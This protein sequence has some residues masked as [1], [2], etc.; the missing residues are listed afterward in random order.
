MRSPCGRA[1]VCVHVDHQAQ[2][3]LGAALGE[4]DARL[5]QDFVLAFARDHPDETAVLRVIGKLAAGDPYLPGVVHIPPLRLTKFWNTRIG[6]AQMHQP[7]LPEGSVVIA[8]AENDRLA[9]RRS[10]SIS[11]RAKATSGPAKRDDFR[12]PASFTISQAPNAGPPS[13]TGGNFGTP[14]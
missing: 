6:T 11:V 1:C 3:R 2:Q 4:P 14:A 10:S 9:H 8:L 12:V 5:L 13:G 7:A